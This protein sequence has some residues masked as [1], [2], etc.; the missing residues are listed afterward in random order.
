MIIIVNITNQN[1]KL[2]DCDVF[3]RKGDI[4]DDYH[5]YAMLNQSIALSLFIR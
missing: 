5:W 2:H 3:I 1:P 4:P